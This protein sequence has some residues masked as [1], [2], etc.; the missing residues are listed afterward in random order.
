[1]TVI[2]WR[3]WISFWL[4]YIIQCLD[5]LLTQQYVGDNWKNENFPPMSLCIKY[6]GIDWSLWVARVLFFS[7]LFFCLKYRD[8][9]RITNVL[10]ILNLCYWASMVQWLFILGFL[11][12]IFIF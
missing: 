7:F 10:F 8:S 9:H 6:L 2:Q 3:F 4:I 1:M 11:K 12:W 5:M